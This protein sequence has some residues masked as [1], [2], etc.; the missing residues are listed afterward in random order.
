[1][2][3]TVA[4]ILEPAVGDP[5]KM[6]DHSTALTWSITSARRA[7]SVREVIYQGTNPARIELAQQLK[8]K[9][10]TVPK[11][12]THQAKEHFARIREFLHWYAEE[13][14]EDQLPDHLAVLAE[15]RPLR[16]YNLIDSALAKL[17]TMPEGIYGLF[18]VFEAPRRSEPIDMRW[19]DG[20]APDQSPESVPI[21]LRSDSLE[22]YRTKQ[23]MASE[24]S[25]AFWIEENMIRHWIN[26]IYCLDLD[27]PHGLKL[28][29][30]ML[31][32]IECD[33]IERTLRW[34]RVKLLVLDVDGTLTPGTIYYST[35]GE[36]LK[37]FHTH[38]GHGIVML[39]DRGIP[40]AIITR[41]PTGF[42]SARARKL[43]IEEVG[44][45]IRDKGPALRSVCERFGVTLD[46]VAYVGDDVGDLPAME[47]VA[48]AGGIA[49]AVADARPEIIAISNYQCDRPGGF[50][51]VRDVCDRILAA[52]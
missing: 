34:D 22:L 25:E 38:D 7:S 5:P 15:R 44:L 10:R 30:S 13:H 42:T 32:S 52:L 33:R 1:M 19:V 26:V 14:G 47:L 12:Q 35:E 51:A 36:E 29:K 45:G 46:E 48:N 39:K 28:S 2:P 16:P 41:E 11:S 27:G 31:D 20:V 50:G 21:V 23:I 8:V 3:D 17:R 40:V 6:P 37:R 9:T 18:T 49:C 43:G 4:L 24:R